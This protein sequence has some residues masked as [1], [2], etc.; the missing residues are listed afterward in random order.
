VL[1]EHKVNHT[2]GLVIGRGKIHPT[3]IVADTVELGQSVVIGAYSIIEGHVT[4][5]DNTHIGNHVHIKGPTTIGKDNV[6]SSFSSIGC[7]PQDKKYHSEESYL[8]IG[9]ANSIRE[10]VTISRG[11]EHGGLITNIGSY[12]LFMAYAHIAHD[13]FIGDS[14]ILANGASLAGHVHIGNFVGMGGFSGVHQFTKI[15]SYAFCGGGSIITKDV[16]PY[17][18]VSGHPAKLIGLNLEGLKRHGFNEEERLILKE[19]YKK[20]FRESTNIIEDAVLY[21]K[22]NTS[23]LIQLLLQFIMSSQRGITR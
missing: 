19:I 12:N 17:T 16:P 21:A 13:C 5:G 15:G 8:K 22:E 6:I 11:T 2:K 4:I 7:D 14:N 3:A 23:P 10:Y 20:L 18:L 9:D 1:K